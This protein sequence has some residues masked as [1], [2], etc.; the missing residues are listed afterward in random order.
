VNTRFRG[1]DDGSIA[2]DG[3]EEGSGVMFSGP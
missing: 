3:N 2:I 1:G